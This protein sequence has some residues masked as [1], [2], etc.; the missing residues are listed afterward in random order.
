MTAFA[1]HEIKNEMGGLKWSLR[2][3]NHRYLEVVVRLPEQ[4]RGL[5]SELRER[6]ATALGRGKIECLLTYTPS[7]T[8]SDQITVNDALANAV[9]EAS[10]RVE[11]IMNNP[12]RISAIE[13]LQWPGV[14]LEAE[15]DT[16]PLLSSA[17]A[18]FDDALKELVK[19]REREGARLKKTIMQRCEAIIAIAAKVRGRRPKVLAAQRQKLMSRIAE[20]EFE[21][22]NHRLEQELVFL[23]QKLD[24]EEEVDR[25]D[26]HCKEA[27]DVLERNEPIGR[28]L[29]FLMQ[30]LNREVNTLGSK[31]ADIETTEAVV[32][33]KVLIEQIREQVQNIE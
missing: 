7:A 31:S 11:A 27:V 12:A 6:V 2:S 24:V 13:I 17:L 10:H 14:T 21:L 28:R 23:A 26:S 18:A 15:M 30:E 25:L 29:D 1:Y 8:L 5:E 22:D 3:L 32:E 33:L 20:L 9:V 4:F 19:G 16:A